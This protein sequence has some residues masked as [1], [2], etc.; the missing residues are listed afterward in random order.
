VRRRTRTQR[1]QARQP[2]R[3]NNSA[4]AKG[5]DNVNNTGT[6]QS[7]NPLDGITAAIESAIQQA[8]EQADVIINDA[9]EEAKQIIAD[10][11][12]EAEQIIADAGAQANTR[13]RA[14][15]ERASL[16]IQE[17]AAALHTIALGLTGHEN[18]RGGDNT[19]NA[20]GSADDDSSGSSDAGN[21]DTN[22]ASNDSD[23]NASA[24]DADT[25]P[26]A[27][28][29]TNPNNT[30]T[31]TSRA[32]TPTTR[33]ANGTARKLAPWETPELETTADNNDATRPEPTPTPR[34]DNNTSNTTSAD[35]KQEATAPQWDAPLI[36]DAPLQF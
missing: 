30:P 1:K 5:K 15:M 12:A 2:T 18:A 34:A 6:T 4:T 16:A 22:E 8:R 33:R 10:A 13:A 14:D 29:V 3:K 36:I 17:H 27:P 21:A 31:T 19:G 35:N 23:N 32:N 25:I 24:N 20:S 26:P 9:H 7:A 11:R 28:T